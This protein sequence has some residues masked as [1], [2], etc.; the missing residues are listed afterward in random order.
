MLLAFVSISSLSV[1]GT[2][3]LDSIIVT[4]LGP[5]E[6]TAVVRL[7]DGKAQL[8]KLGDRIPGTDATVVQVSDDKIVVED[9]NGTTRDRFVKQIVWIYKSPASDGKSKIQRLNRKESP[10]MPGTG[11]VK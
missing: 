7:P 8:V 2:N 6:G 9:M 5:A 3:K 11:S 10:H 4:E 1:A